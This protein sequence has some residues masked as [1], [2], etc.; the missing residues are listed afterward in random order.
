MIVE[1]IG[2][3]GSG[4]TTLAREVARL[5]AAH[6]FVEASDVV[7]GRARMQRLSNS[8]ARNMVAD[9]SALIE[10]PRLDP[11][12]RAFVRYALASLGGSLPVS[13]RMFNYG[14]SV[15][16]R[17]GMDSIAQRTAPDRIVLAD[18]GVLLSVYLLFV[19]GNRSHDVEELAG[20]LDVAPL[21]DRVIHVRAPVATLE[22]RAVSRSDPRPDIV[23]RRLRA[24]RT[25]LDRAIETFDALAAS[26]NL[27]DRVHTIENSNGSPERLAELAGELV[28][29]I[30]GWRAEILGMNGDER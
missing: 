5:G 1:F 28:E 19:Y 14:R 21:P 23:D 22:E 24:D 25:V 4:K 8:T 7:V 10:I 30:D 16:R 13:I 11:D 27:A 18:E 17:T 20:F 12:R 3:S 15:I 9:L 6:G 2:P 26:P 29:T